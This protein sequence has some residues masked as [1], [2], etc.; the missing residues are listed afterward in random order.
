[1]K[2]S[3]KFILQGAGMCV[4]VLVFLTE[5]GNILNIFTYRIFS[6][7]HLAHDCHLCQINVTIR[8]LF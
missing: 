7:R 8:Y 6:D 1:M 3:I 4:Y 5:D 2:G